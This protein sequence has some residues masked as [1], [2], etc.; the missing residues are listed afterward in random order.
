[1]YRASLIRKRSLV[2]VQAGPP[3]EG[4]YLSG[5]LYVYGHVLPDMQDKAT[6]AMDDALGGSL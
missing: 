1:M 4:P 5:M 6:R 3:E 2:R